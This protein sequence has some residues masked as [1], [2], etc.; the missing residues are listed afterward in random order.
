MAVTSR[1]RYMQMNRM[2][3]L[4][5]I[6]HP[7]H[8]FRAA[9]GYLKPGDIAIDCGANVGDITEQLLASGCKV[10][11]FEPDPA[12]FG[13]LHQRFGTIE[14][15]VIREVAVGV[16]AGHQRLYYHKERSDPGAPLIL[17]Q[18]STLVADKRNVSKDHFVDVEVIDFGQ[19]LEQL[20]RRIAILK[21]DIE[22][23]EADIL[24]MILE[25]K[26]Y[27]RFDIAFVE[28]HDRKVPSTRAK[29]QYI[30]SEIESLNIN[31]IFLDWK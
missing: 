4:T 28:T 7:L 1:V 8:R 27:D 9:L 26:L 14:G 5:K 12:A 19:F 23:M 21:L 25:R 29:L 3:V 10:Y 2:D 16:R 6:E 13:V 11:A 30:R 18:G 17:T 15:A 31:H 24:E 20:D 22:G